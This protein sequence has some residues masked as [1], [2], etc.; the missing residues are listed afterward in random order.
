MKGFATLLIAIFAVF[1]V[2]LRREPDVHQTRTDPKIG[3][4]TGVG[5]LAIRVSDDPDARVATIASLSRRASIGIERRV[6]I[7][8]LR[9]RVLLDG[10]EIFIPG[11]ND[12]KTDQITTQFSAGF[13]K[14]VESWGEPPE[15]FHWV[16]TLR[17]VV[18]PSGNDIYERLQ[19][20]LKRLIGEI[21]EKLGIQLTEERIKSTP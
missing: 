10:K 2:Q 17:F 15:R 16:P 12:A 19:G 4:E 11:A 7:R 20:D 6:E 21:S 5:S 18:D 13:A 9:D 14:V 1:A 3:E 8:V